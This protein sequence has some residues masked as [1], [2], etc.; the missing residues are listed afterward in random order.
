MGIL[1][2]GGHGFIVFLSLDDNRERQRA[3]GEWDLAVQA[4]GKDGDLWDYCSE[5]FRPALNSLEKTTAAFRGM[6]VWKVGSF[7]SPAKGIMRA[8]D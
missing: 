7:R 8:S 6:R 1:E 5:Y 2:F 3:A 4:N